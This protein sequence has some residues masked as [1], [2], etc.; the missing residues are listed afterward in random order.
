MRTQTV[1]A[2]LTLYAPSLGEASFRAPRARQQLRQQLGRVVRR[3]PRR[4]MDARADAEPAPRLH[5][6]AAADP[7]SRSGS[8]ERAARARHQYRQRRRPPRARARD[9]R[10]QQQQGRPASPEPRAG[11]PP[12][13]AGHHVSGLITACWLEG[14]RVIMLR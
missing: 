8:G 13:Q 3:L 4:G 10:V 9:V 1:R 7:E 14:G 6:D 5:R 11:E 12:G 2:R